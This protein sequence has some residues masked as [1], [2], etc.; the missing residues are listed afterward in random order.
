MY[1]PIH[2][3][4]IGT[5]GSGKTTLLIEPAIRILS[6]T[7]EKPCLVITDPKGEL[8]NNHSIQLE[9]NGYRLMTLDLRN[10]YASNGQFL[11]DVPQGSQT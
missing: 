1:N 2:T 8:F 5:T 3:L 7:G 4:V 9:E 6:K 11:Y 10:P